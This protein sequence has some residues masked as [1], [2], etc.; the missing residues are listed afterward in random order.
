MTYKI[1]VTEIQKTNTKNAII[2]TGAPRSGTSL[3]GKLVST[4]K[5]ID[6][7][8]EPPMIWALASLLSMKELSQEV[9]S[10]LL[11][12][13]LHE[14]LLLESVHGRKANLRPGDDSLV[15]NSITW[16]EL[17]LRW[18][19]I[20]NREDAIRYISDKHLR[21]AFKS[22]SVIDA[23]PFFANALPESKFIIIMRNGQ[24]VAQ[25]IIRKKWLS[26]EGL[27]NNYWPYKMIAGNKVPHLVEDSMVGKWVKMNEV[28]RACYLWRRDAEFAIRAKDSN[29][30]SR[31]HF[32]YYEDLRSE[33]S[34]IMDA[35]ATFL[36]TKITDL[37]KLGI[38]S[39]RP[40]ASE[41]APGKTYDFLK[42]VETQELCK[43]KE[44]N[45]AWGY[46]Q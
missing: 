42:E 6:Y 4:L 44:L 32:I 9:A 16:A 14:D 15:L 19:N 35:I 13:Y 31:L 12:L 43:F 27:E 34:I 21:L 25:S 28:T 33:P 5:D 20:H 11:Q 1:R 46:A 23:I 29:F 8:F 10:I 17:L 2:I 24:D 39:V 7:H 37:T 18:H 45:A 30:G 40:M 36:S 41:L 26:D 22:P 38:M 3:L